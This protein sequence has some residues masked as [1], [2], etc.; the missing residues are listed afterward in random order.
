MGIRKVFED[1]RFAKTFVL[2]F[3]INTLCIVGSQVYALPKLFDGYWFYS[4]FYREVFFAVSYVALLWLIYQTRL[5]FIQNLLLG[6]VLVASLVAF[7]VNVFLLYHFHSNL[8]SYLLSVGLQSNARE[9]GEFLATYFTLLLVCVYLAVGVCLW[10]LWRSVKPKASK[11]P[12][13]VFVLGLVFLIPVH[14]FKLRPVDERW[15]DVLYNAYA[16]FQRSLNTMQMMQDFAATSKDMDALVSK[17]SLAP[18][19]T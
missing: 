8:H 3:V 11:I 7:V 4:F 16:S 17:L 9:A 13:I 10:L 2:L 15:S 6:L 5:R 1:A 18:Q 14:I 19:F 12:G